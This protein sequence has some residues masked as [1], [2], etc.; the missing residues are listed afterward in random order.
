MHFHGFGATASS[1][2]KEHGDTVDTVRKLQGGKRKENLFLEGSAFSGLRLPDHVDRAT[3]FSLGPGPWL[4]Q[5][6]GFLEPKNWRTWVWFF[7]STYA[8]SFLQ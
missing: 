3:M 1:L 7:C 4:L 8:W 6:P 5:D 2:Q